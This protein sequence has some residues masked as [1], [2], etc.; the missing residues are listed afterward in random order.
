MKTT[1]GDRQARIHSF[2]EG[3]KRK[4]G[5]E[6]NIHVPPLRRQRGSSR[7]HLA[8]VEQAEQVSSKDVDL[9]ER[10]PEHTRNKRKGEKRDV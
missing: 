5:R 3:G 1:D 8:E 10:D 2:Q 6:L 4:G 9:K 7:R